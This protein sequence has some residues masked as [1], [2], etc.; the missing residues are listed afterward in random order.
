MRTYESLGPVSQK[1][2]LLLLGGLALGL[3]HS[4]N[5]YF[6]ILKMIG[7]EWQQINTR[8][9]QRAIKNLYKARLI[10]T[11][12]NT[13]GTTTVVLTEK[14]KKKA[15][16][17]NIDEIKI[18]PMKKWDRKWRFILFDIPESRK[19]ARDA[20]S[21]KLKTAGFYKLQKSVFVSPFDCRKEIDFIIE[22][23]AVR[24]YVR[25]VVADYIDNEPHLKKIFRIL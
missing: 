1:I 23:F 22:F 3:S 21:L 4:P 2:L 20:L 9:M 13:D 6:R 14:G 24:P 17:Y 7:K 15:L 12:D 11:K 16:T 10:D 18:Q 8:A 19:K 25:I 5:R